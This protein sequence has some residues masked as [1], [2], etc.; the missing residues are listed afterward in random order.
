[1]AI[2]N[3]NCLDTSLWTSQGIMGELL[4]E[5]HRELSGPEPAP[6]PPLPKFAKSKSGTQSSPLQKEAPK[7][8]SEAPSIDYNQPNVNL[9]AAV[10][11]ALNTDHYINQHVNMDMADPS[12]DSSTASSSSEEE[13]NSDV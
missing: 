8:S 1:M 12:R 5:I 6:L 10:S 4:E 11:T 7:T 9:T 13:D 2:H 3:E